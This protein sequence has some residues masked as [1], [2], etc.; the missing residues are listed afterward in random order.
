MLNVVLNLFMVSL[1][2]CVMSD[3]LSVVSGN[4]L[5]GGRDGDSE[6][7]GGNSETASV[8]APPIRSIMIAI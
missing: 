2:S 6:S 8:S 1:S 5:L 4:A 7:G 3:R